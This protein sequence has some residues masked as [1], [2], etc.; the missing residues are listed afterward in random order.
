MA[1]ALLAV[2][3]LAV[4]A[5]ATGCGGRLMPSSE[6]PGGAAGIAVTIIWPERSNGRLIPQKTE[7]IRVDIEDGAVLVASHLEP[8][9][10]FA[11]A[12]T[13]PFGGLT[14]Y[15]TYALKAFAH[16]TA[17]GGGIPLALA[18]VEATT[19]GPGSE[20]TVPVTLSSAVES[21]EVWPSNPT[22]LVGASIDFGATSR[23][24]SG[25][26][27]LTPDVEWSESSGGTLARIDR[28]GHFTALATGTVTVTARE[29]ESGRTGQAVVTITGS[30]GVAT[31]EVLPSSASL[32]VGGTTDFVA[33][34]KDAS[35]NAVGTPPFQWSESSGGALAT[36]AAN[37]HFVALAGG[38]V[39]V[40]AREPGSGVTGQATVTIIAS[41]TV[42]RVEVT[43]ASATVGVGG[44]IDF[45]AVAKDAAG[46]VMATPPFQWSESSNGTVATIAP[47]GHF[48][49]F[50]E[51][52]VAVTA[53]DTDS[54]VTGQAVVTITPSL[55]VATVQATPSSTTVGVGGTIDF[56]AVARNAAGDVVATLPFQWSA[57]SG[58][59]LA[60]IA[61]NGHFT[62]LGQG[63]VTVTARDS[64]SGV[65][66]Q[67][68]VTIIASTTVTT[69]QV[70]PSSAT[71]SVGGTI[72]FAAVAKDASGSNVLG[73]TFQWTESSG[74]VLATID[75][76]GH[77]TALAAGNVT[78]TARE[79]GS[80]VTGQGSVRVLAAVAGRIVFVSD[81]D[82]NA[83]IYAMNPDG[84]NQTNLTNN[85]AGDEYPSWSPGQSRVVFDS[86]RE[87]QADIYVM[88][89]DGSN[90]T[91][92]TTSPGW[93]GGAS[94]SPDASRIA[95]ASDRDGNYEIYVMN[96]DGTS[97]TRLT[98]N[99]AVD[100]TPRWSPD[101]R[102]IAFWSDRGGN[103][104]IYVM[105]ADGT[106]ATNLTNSPGGNFYP[107]WSPDG[108]KIAFNSG[109]TGSGDI[110]VMNSDGT[111]R[112]RLASGGAAPSWSPDGTRIAFFSERDGNREIYA[113][114][115][116]GTNLTRLTSNAARDEYPSWS[117]F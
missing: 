93:D 73:A 71:V 17:D 65:T 29:T 49:A 6:G 102:K 22:L 27:V 9:P 41:P 76:N 67:A 54:G 87:G 70:T 30:S 97:Q 26:A 66:G 79:T 86:A 4:V 34:A 68:I 32:A 105:N 16:P 100:W 62:A 51:G 90:Q 114:N 61:Q 20:A 109:T 43:P 47:N 38:S 25:R 28:T 57:S 45:L 40:T 1:K 23:D 89:A 8:R 42:A 3:G 59:T 75:Q 113:V 101:G 115:S 95:F 108:T 64:T 72:G 58:G 11:A 98:N 56:T 19:L 107:S 37:G 31:V 99:S 63:T 83:E 46:N 85:P 35:G 91:R 116:G 44:E 55:T 77:F 80:G 39:T 13:L 78:V 111:G 82:G 84:T 112:A 50:A 88:N 24:N 117:P 74:G 69:V 15:H 94:F 92:L 18:T 14:P 12:V 110:Y 60:T 21:V 33:V 10:E 48:T 104:D 81:R 53:R 52:T 106:S 5:I 7:S 103:Y 2:L 96:S 36:I